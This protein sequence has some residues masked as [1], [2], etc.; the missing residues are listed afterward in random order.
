MP[1]TIRWMAIQRMQAFLYLYL[2]RA[3]LAIFRQ[4]FIDDKAVFRFF[5]L[6][7]GQSKRLKAHPHHSSGAS[8]LSTLSADSCDSILSD[9]IFAQMDNQMID[10]VPFL[11]YYRLRSHS[12][13]IRKSF[14]ITISLFYSYFICFAGIEM[15]E[16]L[17]NELFSLPDLK[18]LMSCPELSTEAF[19]SIYPD[20]TIYERRMEPPWSPS[21]SASSDPPP[22]CFRTARQELMARLH[23]SLK[24]KSM[25]L[26]A[27]SSITALTKADPDGDT[28]V[29][30]FSGFFGMNLKMI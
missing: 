27:K 15:T 10:Q 20:Y 16:T 23:P 2:R 13:W 5:R 7:I 24:E 6:F 12:N 17:L 19:Q 1:E 9:D 11:S 29:I 22:G 28:L 3:G 26:V 4:S 30:Y 8:V 21:D 25:K 18:Q 14:T